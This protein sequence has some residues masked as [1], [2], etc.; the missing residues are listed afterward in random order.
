MPLIRSVSGL[1]ATTTDG[2]LSDEVVCRHI[3]AFAQM[4][5]NGAL[6]VGYDGRRGGQ[7]IAELVADQL[8]RCGRNVLEL[9]CVPTP[10]VQLV[11]ERNRL[12]GGVVV[13]ASHNDAEWNGLKFLDADGVFLLP[14]RAAMLWQQSDRASAP[15]SG[16]SGTRTQHSDPIGE[17]IAALEQV[18]FIAQRRAS[19]AFEGMRI[20]LDA[21]N[22]SGSRALPALME[23]LG[24]QPIAV[25]CDG[26][27]NFPHPPEPLPAHLTELQ[28]KTAEHH[29]TVGAALDPDGDRLVLVHGSGQPVSEEKTIVLATESVLRFLGGGVVVVNASTTSE[30]EHIAQRYGAQVLRS[31]VGEVNV[32]TLMRSSGAVVGGEGSGGVILPA[33]HYGRD[34]LVG[35]ALVLAL[36]SQLSDTEWDE[37]LLAAPLVMH[38]RTL[39]WNGNFAAVK[40]ELGA[41]FPDASEVWTGD[42][43]RFRW[44]D[45]WLHIR[46][47]NTEPILRLIAESP[48]ADTTVD[49]LDRAETLLRGYAD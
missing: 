49:L 34:A 35:I 16:V 2:A 31:A 22:A 33:C 42:G 13:T 19:G 26:S 10:T 28:R 25:F 27:G 29:A 46:S 15:A 8:A 6:A 30:V 41:A 12:A 39:R 36:R 44:S 38:K 45:R 43:I 18:E 21:V 23:W 3:R 32:V 5:P 47:S 20:T 4:Q 37:R 17:H 9:G 40:E 48:T 11:V 24:A 1:R 7:E 14:E